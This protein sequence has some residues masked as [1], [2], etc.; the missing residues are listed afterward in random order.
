MHEKIENEWMERNRYNKG[1][2]IG[3][4]QFKTDLSGDMTI[5]EVIL[6]IEKPMRLRNDEKKEGNDDGIFCKELLEDVW[7]DSKDCLW[8]YVVS[9]DY[10]AATSDIR[11]KCQEKK[12]VR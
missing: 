3:Y 5:E 10:I 9:M 1:K 11:K 4:R 7:L 2:P 8:R 12:K 6:A